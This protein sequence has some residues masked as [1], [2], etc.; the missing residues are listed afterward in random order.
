MKLTI[1]E[2]IARHDV[3]LCHLIVDPDVNQEEK[4]CAESSPPRSVKAVHP[5]RMQTL[6]NRIWNFRLFRKWVLLLQEQENRN[7]LSFRRPTCLSE[8]CIQD[9]LLVR[10][11]RLFVFTARRTLRLV[12]AKGWRNRKPVPTF[13]TINIR[14]IHN[15]SILELMDESV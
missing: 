1:K 12:S 9:S 11:H 2:A 13:S 3:V 7:T 4:D 8:C 14:G 15:I 5:F 6:G 10:D